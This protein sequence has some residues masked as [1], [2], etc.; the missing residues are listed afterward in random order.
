M[1]QEILPSNTSVPLVVPYAPAEREIIYP[2]SDEEPMAETDVHRD[3]MLNLISMLKNYFNNRPDVYVSGNLFL[4]YDEGNPKASVAPDVFVVF[5]V[6]KK[7]RRTYRM[8]KEGKGPDFVLELVSKSTYEY[9]LGGKKDLYAEVLKAKE[10]FLYDPDDRYLTSQLMGY[11]LTE[12]GVYLPIKRTAKGHL[13]SFKL[14]LELG[15]R[16]MELG[17]YEPQTERWL[18]NPM[19]ESDARKQAEIK[20]LQESFARKLAE[21]KAERAEAELARLRALL[22]Q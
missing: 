9:D 3:L 22:D 21:R 12:D 11:C 18:L 20:A 15:V 8:W 6:E 16:D 7:R 4:Y 19:E 2:E 5:G 13:P 14:S 17:L 1:A 10:Y